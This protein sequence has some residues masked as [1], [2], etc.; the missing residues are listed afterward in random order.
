[1]DIIPYEDLLITT[2]TIVM[3]LSNGI[4]T[5]AAFHLLPI[6]RIAIQQTRQSSKCKLPHC[7]IPG[8]ILSMRYRENVRGVIRSDSKP[9]KNAVT[10]DVST[11]R[12]N[13]SLKLSSFSIQMCG[14]SSREDGI[15]AATHVLNHLKHIQFVLNKIQSNPI[16]AL[17]AID[18]VKTNTLSNEIEKEFWEVQEFINVTLRIYRPIKENSIVKPLGPVPDNLD[19]DI[20][21]FL[22]SLSDD[23]I[24]HS[25]MCRKLDFIPN[26]HIIIDEPLEL[27]NV[28]EAMVNY[29]YSL[30]FEVDRANLNRFIDG[31]SGFISRYNNAL[32]TSVTIELPYEPPAGTAIKRRKNKIPHH[33]FLVYKSGSVTQSGPGGALMR[34]A[35]YLFMNTIAQLQPYIQYVQPP[36]NYASAQQIVYNVDKVVNN[37]TTQNPGIIPDDSLVTKSYDEILNVLT[38]QTSDLHSSIPEMSYQLIQQPQF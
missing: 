4:N 12:K 15:E 23:F 22:I 1:M 32:A 7:E 26:I 18:W 8:S 10:I 6:T 28:D 25:D 38:K 13:I 34:D 20:V 14:A 2:M 11:I 16:G 35:Y 9:F 36:L 33:T 29:N 5:E 27:K 3:T 17:Q 21:G 24:Y 37:Y 31:Q 19:K 30:G